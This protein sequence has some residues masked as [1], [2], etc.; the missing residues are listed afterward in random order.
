MVFDDLGLILILRKY[1]YIIEEYNGK[2]KIYFQ[3]IGEIEDKWFVFQF[4]VVFFRFVQEV[5]FNVLK[6]FEF[7]EIIVKVEIIKDFVILMIKDNGKGFDLKEVKE[8]K[9][10]LFG[11]LGM[12]ERVD[13]LEGIMII[14]L[15]IG[16][17]IFIMIKVLLFF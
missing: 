8:K 16:F 17:G 6:Y 9:N 4:E 2:V 15:K 5:V 7:E 11:L 12:K 10:K 14:D 1:L 13:L 3:C